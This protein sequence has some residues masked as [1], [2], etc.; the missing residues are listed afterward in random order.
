MSLMILNETIRGGIP[1]LVTAKKFL[2]IIEKQHAGS[3]K[4]RIGLL[5]DKLESI[6]FDRQESV[7]AHIL[8]IADLLYQLKDLGL[9]MENDYIVHKSVN[10]LP[11]AFDT[12]KVHYN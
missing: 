1:T 7:R 9:D 6:R 8:H 10:S 2:E 12:F 5:M 4:A 11:R 3:A